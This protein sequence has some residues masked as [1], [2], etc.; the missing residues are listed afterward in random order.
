MCLGSA[1]DQSTDIIHVQDTL[2]QF[3]YFPSS[4]SHCNFRFLGCFLCSSNISFRPL[5]PLL[6]HTPSALYIFTFFLFKAQNSVSHLFKTD[7]YNHSQSRSVEHFERSKYSNEKPHNSRSVTSPS[8]PSPSRHRTSATES[9]AISTMGRG[10][11][12]APQDSGRG[13]YN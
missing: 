6:L 5:F 3:Q 10:G 11:Y 1:S 7:P 13:G 4:K 2:T 12:N 9:K 8:S